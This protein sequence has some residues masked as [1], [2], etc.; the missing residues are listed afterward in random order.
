MGAGGPR[1]QSGLPDHTFSAG[2]FYFAVHQEI[3]VKPEPVGALQLT[4]ASS[5]QERNFPGG[6]LG[7]QQYTEGDGGH[8]YYF[9][10]SSRIGYRNAQ[11]AAILESAAAVF[12][13]AEVDSFYR[14]LMPIFQAGLP[15]TFLYP[16]VRTTPAHRL[17][18]GLSSPYRDDPL[19]HA[20]EL[21]LDSGRSGKDE[22]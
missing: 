17:V 4:F 14:E 8:R 19:C 20:G 6:Y 2:C 22:K 9:G 18:R 13:P 5:R 12:N 7:R 1:F 21:S 3:V 11:V 16:L 10:S 15:V